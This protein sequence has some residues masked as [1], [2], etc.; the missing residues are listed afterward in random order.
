MYEGQVNQNIILI[1]FLF[2]NVISRKKEI[3]LLKLVGMD[4]S[5][6]I[7]MLMNKNGYYMM[8][9]LVITLLGGV[10]ISYGLHIYVNNDSIFGGL[11][12]KFPGFEFLLYA[13]VI[14]FIGRIILMSI[15]KIM[16]KKRG[17]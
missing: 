6:R 12:Y 7:N 3:S 2:F 1:R 15:D 8:R 11:Q 14:Y 10:I 5:Q 4:R 16:N 13:I 17:L 9:I